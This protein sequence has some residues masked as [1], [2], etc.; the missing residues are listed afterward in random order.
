[1]IAINLEKID[2]K[3][4]LGVSLP[5]DQDLM[6]KIKKINGRKWSNSRS[7]WLIPYTKEAWQHFKSS[8][9]NHKIKLIQE[10]KNEHNF[11]KGLVLNDKNNSIN[12]VRITFIPGQKGLLSVWIK[13]DDLF[14]RLLIKKIPGRQWH[15]KLARWTI[16]YTSKTI[17]Q[18]QY[19]F[20]EQCW[21]DFDPEKDSAIS[22]IV[23]NQNGVKK[24]GRIKQTSPWPDA[25]C[26]MEQALCLIRY[27]RHTIKTYL[28]FFKEYT[29]WLGE[30]KRPEDQYKEQIKHFLFQWIKYKK[31]SGTAQNQMINAIKF[32]YE[33][34]LKR[35]RT[36][37]DLPR[38][39]KEIH[40]PKIFSE[41]EIKMLLQTP[42]NVKHQCIL[43]TIYSTGIRLSELLNLRLQDID[44]KRMSVFIKRGKGKKDRYTVL[45]PM[46]LKHLRH[47]YKIYFPEFWLFEGQDGGQYSPRSVQQILRNAISKSGVNSFGTVHTLRHSF[48]THLL[49]NGTDLRYIQHLLGHGSTKTTEIYTHITKHHMA[50]LKSPLDFLGMNEPLRNNFFVNEKNKGDIGI[51][52]LQL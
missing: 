37:Y 3:S 25:M 41:K 39:R 19:L 7:K 32:Y 10:I 2:S 23:T 51:H 27:S 50:K 14:S 31:A 20:G 44:S 1:M 16:P 26:D 40:L 34:V 28:C 33:K 46:L 9:K 18:L 6:E 45:S 4:F 52:T 22:P 42:E 29:I 35:E 36:V 49:E 24:A 38:P 43:L 11:N 8:F 15:P 48:A 30:K 21:F 47:Y 13:W 17:Q 5:K 12:L